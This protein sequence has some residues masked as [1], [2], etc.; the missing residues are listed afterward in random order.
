MLNISIIIPVYNVEDY[1]PQCL[2]SVLAQTFT[3]FEVICVNDGATDNSAGVLAA[4]SALDSRIK[5]INQD[6]RGLSAARNRGLQEASGRYVYFLDSDDC[7]HPQLLE[8]CYFFAEHYQADLVNFCY[9]SFK[10]TDFPLFKNYSSVEDIPFTLEAEPLF[11]KN[12]NYNVWSKFYRRSL[13][14]EHSFISG[15]YFEDYPFCVTLL[16]TRPSTVVINEKLYFYRTDNDSIT[17][18]LF[19]VKKIRDYQTGL[20]YI[21]ERCY[22][23]KDTCIGRFIVENIVPDILKHQY[24]GIRRSPKLLRPELWDAFRKEL[25]A[26]EQRGWLQRRGHKL[27][28]YWSYRYLLRKK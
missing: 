23:N 20:N 22:L 25:H 16:A 10:G 17:R 3:D 8:I 28:R 4:Y 11:S 9:E 21:Y 6:N 24:N 5:I 27:W 18:S 2:N 14:H 12:V 7:I 26:L 19:S 15:I 1:L 13:L